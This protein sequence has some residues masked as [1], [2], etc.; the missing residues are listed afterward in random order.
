MRVRIR[1]RDFFLAVN[2]RIVALITSRDS[3]GRP[4]AMAASWH[5]PISFDP[6]LYGVSISPARYSHDSI[7][8]SGVFGVN[9]LPYEMAPSV[10]ACGRISMAERRDKL[11]LARVTV[12]D[13]PSR[14]PIVEESY[15]ALECRLVDHRTYGDHTLF[16][17][18]VLTV[19]A[20]PRALAPDSRVDLGSVRPLLYLGSDEYLTVK[21]ESL[22]RVK[23]PA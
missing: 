22:V 21:P 9:F 17:G 12:V 15:V 20:K 8:D 10:H 18:E 5:C 16:V 23:P 14:V 2:P 3:E 6:P 19:T 11:E 4:N 13:G 1:T 7:R